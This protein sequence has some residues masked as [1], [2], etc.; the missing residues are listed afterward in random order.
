M[1][2]RFLEFKSPSIKESK[3]KSSNAVTRYNTEVGLLVGICGVNP[4]TF[5]PLHPDDPSTGIPASMLKDNGKKVYRDIVTFLSKNFDRALFTEWANKAPE[6]MQKIV[7][8]LGKTPTVFDW[9]G[10]TNKNEEGAA[11][12]EFV[13]MDTHGISVKAA[14]GITLRNLTPKSLGIAVERGNDVF[15]QYAGAEYKAMKEAIFGKLLDE[16]KTKPGINLGFH[17]ETPD[18]YYIVYNPPKNAAPA[19]APTEPA[20]DELSAVKKNAGIPQTPP[21]AEPTPTVDNTQVNE[22]EQPTTQEGTWTCVGK[23]SFTGTRQQIMASVIPN[24]KW[25]RVFGDWFQATYQSNKELA[26]PLYAAISTMFKNTMVQHLAQDRNLDTL[27][28]MGKRSYFYVNDT[29][30]FYV[31][32]ITEISD[33]QLKQVDYGAISSSSGT[34]EE[35]D[36]TSQKFQAQVGRTGS[37]D[38]AKILIYIRYANGM[39]ACNP[40]VRVQDLKDPVY[41]GWEHL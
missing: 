17:R 8:K 10:G 13:N 32:S 4:E 28:A 30:T 22:S 37:T 25:H 11:D 34:L 31:P 35:A 3:S 18:K 12:I 29:D 23:T 20:T 33:L 26:K 7:S 27:L 21:G 38:N 41:L 40:T 14:T 2:M 5:D 1:Y 19:A 24:K 39:F 36:G 16:A 15:Y 9:A 6:Y